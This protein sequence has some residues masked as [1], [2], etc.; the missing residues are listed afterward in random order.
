MMSRWSFVYEGFDPDKENLREALCTLGNGY[1]ATRG[2]SPDAEA[3]EIH[4]PGTYLAGGYNRLKTD[5][6]GRTIENEDLVNLPNWLPLTFR[7]EGGE[8]FNLMAVDLLSYRQELDM[9]QGVLTRIIR[10]REKDRR[11]THMTNRRFVHMGDEHLAAM[12]T[13]LGAENW[14]GRVEVRSALDGQVVNAG[15]ERYRQLKSKHLEPLAS[16]EIGEDAIYLK[17]QT[18]ESKLQIAQAARTRVFRDVQCVPVKRT[19]LKEDGRVEQRFTV[20]VAEG[21][22]VRIEKVVSLFTSR[23]H[24]ISECGLEARKAIGRAGSFRELLEPHRLAWD[25]LWRRFDIEFDLTEPEEGDRTSSI[26]H[27]YL[28]HVLQTCSPH[29]MDLDVGVPSRGWHGEAYRGHVFWDELFVFPLLNLRLPEITRALLKYRFRRLDEARVAAQEAGYRGA[30]YPWQSGSDGREESQQVHLNPKSG[31]WIPDNSQLQRHVNAAIAYNVFQYYQVSGDMEFLSFYGA[32]IFLEIAR[33]WASMAT[34]NLDMERYEILGVMGP[35][36]YHDAYPDSD[37]PGLNN[38][39]YTNIMVVWILCRAQ[40]ILEMLPEDRAQELR[41]S[42]NLGQKEIEQWLDI[43]RKMRVVFHDDGIISQFEEYGD[44]EE[45]DWE[46][47]RQKYGDIQRLDRILEA[48]GDTPN[49]YKASKQADV[50]MLFYLFSSE[51]LRAIFQRLGYTFEYETIPKNID[52]Y[53]KRTSHGSTL[54]RVA[55]SWVLARSDRA[56][57][58]SFFGEALQ[59]DVADIQGGTTPEGIHLGAMAGTVD[60]VQR[61]Y[62]G[63]EP[64][65]DVLWFNP[66]LPR[67]LARLRLQI[68]YRGHTLELEADSRKMKVSSYRGAKEPIRIGFRGEVFDLHE[69]GMREFDLESEPIRS[70]R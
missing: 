45:F 69:K 24:A 11:I 53:V 7:I 18:N 64:R 5:I 55:H 33:F 62:T 44:L 40:E 50:L 51:E 41:E 20:D 12:E 14:T 22:E 68:R 6:A 32:E 36:E 57:S 10:F 70:S 58:W 2:A 9:K 15:V 56:R 63:I 8:W 60:L 59:S 35:D 67:Q 48:E 54:S 42:L 28:F 34:F 38:N 30:M 21:S 49:R 47:Y 16:E 37:K 39:A 1:F 3:D 13:T 52:Y 27:L 31:R 25:H 46:G 65:G 29:T 4:Y 66:C 17:A 26:L 43:S 61:G 23:D 19:T